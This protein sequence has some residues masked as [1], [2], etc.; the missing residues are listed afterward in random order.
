MFEQFK[1][2]S[3]I[4]KVVSWLRKLPVFVQTLLVLGFLF[5]VNNIYLQR[6]QEKIIAE[7]S[8]VTKRE[9]LMAECYTEKITPRVNKYVQDILMRDT[10]I[11]NIILLNYHNTLTS[12]QGL[13][14]KYLTALTER[15][16]GLEAKS[17]IRLWKELEYIHYGD[18][19]ERIN[20]NQYLIMSD[21]E[22][23]KYS[24]PEFYQLLKYSDSKSA[25]FYPIQGVEQAIGMIVVMYS[26]SK[27]Y[28]SNYY[29]KVM[30]P[31]ISPLVSLLDYNNVKQEF[32]KE[33]E[34][35]QKK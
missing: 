34:N 9:K 35:R 4:I 1:N 6:S 28:P 3:E 20:G 29:E 32:Q 31:S 10:T 5:T 33:Y 11:S 27:K 30:S 14:Y 23:Y 26:T 7:Y 24:F 15:R 12:T 22:K 21:I 18:E 16:N 17:Y 13:S 25:G 2:L 8:E 19:I